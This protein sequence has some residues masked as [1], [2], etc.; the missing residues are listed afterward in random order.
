MDR[1]IVGVLN[2]FSTHHFP[3]HD[4]RELFGGGEFAFEFDGEIGVA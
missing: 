4:V 2:S 3:S 1:K